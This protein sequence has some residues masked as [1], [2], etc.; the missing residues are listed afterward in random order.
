MP[1]GLNGTKKPPDS[2]YDPEGQHGGPRRGGRD[3]RT[4]DGDSVAG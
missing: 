1:P 4:L 3:W 2:P